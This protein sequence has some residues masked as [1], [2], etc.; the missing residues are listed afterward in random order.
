V[1]F[2]QKKFQISEWVTNLCFDLKES[3]NLQICFKRRKK[4]LNENAGLESRESRKHIG[5]TNST[6]VDCFKKYIW[7]FSLND[8]KKLSSSQN[9]LKYIIFE[10]EKTSKVLPFRAHPIIA[11]VQYL[12]LLINSLEKK[13]TSQKSLKE[14]KKRIFFLFQIHPFSKSKLLHERPLIRICLFKQICF[15]FVFYIFWKKYFILIEN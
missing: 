12:K 15:S 1:K 13:K 10:W 3:S 6:N 2:E 11:R 8:F 4:T 5:R 9:A 14:N 7:S